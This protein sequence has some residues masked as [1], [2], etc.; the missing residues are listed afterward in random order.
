MDEIKKYRIVVNRKPGE[1][2][3]YFQRFI[4]QIVC[5]MTSVG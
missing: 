3:E 2:Y 5:L 1:K 4:G